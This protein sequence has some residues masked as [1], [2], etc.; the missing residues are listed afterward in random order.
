MGDSPQILVLNVNHNRNRKEDLRSPKSP[1]ITEAIEISGQLQKSMLRMTGKFLDESTGTVDYKALRSSEEFRDYC[2][3]ASSLEKVDLASF[4]EQQLFAFFINIYNA[5]TVHSI[6]ETQKTSDIG[7]TL[8]VPNFW[9]THGY[10]IGGF[11]FTLDDIEHGILRGNRPHPSTG[12]PVLGQTDPRASFSIKRVDPRIH[13]ALNC[14][15]K[16]CPVVRVYNCSNLDAALEAATES[17]LSQGVLADDNK[18]SLK[19]PKIM[20]WYMSDFA[21]TQAG[22]LKWIE[23]YV[24]PSERQ[25]IKF[26]LDANKGDDT[27][28]VQYLYD[29]SLNKA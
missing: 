4:S 11:I 2:T 9:A 13:F 27:E 19:I 18:R 24:G 21:R 14:G 15:A 25:A 6:C 3:F 16:S 5:L 10:I 1:G 7:T 17:Y 22:M 8:D 29:W 28:S 26:L 23:S 20:L 12:K